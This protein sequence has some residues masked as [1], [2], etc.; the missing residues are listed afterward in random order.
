MKK[1]SGNFQSAKVL[2]KDIQVSQFDV[3]MGYD[4]NDSWNPFLT[5]GRDYANNKYVQIPY[6]EVNFKPNWKFHFAVYDSI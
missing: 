1:R 3:I 6:D 2:C 4:E 5:N